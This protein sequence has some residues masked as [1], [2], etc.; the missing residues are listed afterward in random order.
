MQRPFFPSQDWEVRVFCCV[1]SVYTCQWDFLK[2]T[3]RGCLGCASAAVRVSAPVCVNALAR[4]YKISSRHKH[5][6]VQ[7]A[8]IH[9]PLQHIMNRRFIPVAAFAALFAVTLA[10]G[11]GGH[12]HHHDHAHAHEH[13]HDHGAAAPPLGPSSARLQVQQPSIVDLVAGTPEFSTLLAAVSAAGLVETLA[14]PG[15]FTVFAPS[16]TAFAKIPA[17]ALNGLLADKAA[18]SAVLLRHVVPGTILVSGSFMIYSVLIGPK[19]ICVHFHEYDRSASLKQFKVYC[20][21]LS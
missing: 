18:L 17:D 19:S 15:P 4:P 10:D 5:S 12:H 16:N 14:A 1:C 21:F 20:F 7:S 9:H 6:T 11:P 3:P 13:A 8:P 2:V